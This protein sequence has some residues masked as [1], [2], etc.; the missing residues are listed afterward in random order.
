MDCFRIRARYKVNMSTS[1]IWM[2]GNQWVQVSTARQGDSWRER[3]TRPF[4]LSALNHWHYNWT[5]TIP[6]ASFAKNL[7]TFSTVLL[8]AHTWR[9]QK[10]KEA[11]RFVL[12]SQS[13]II[14]DYC[15]NLQLFF[16]TNQN[17]PPHSS[18]TTYHTFC[19]DMFTK[20]TIETVG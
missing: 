15:N 4:Q 2:K 12:N 5:E 3:A 1:S 19:S 11:W 7:S 14:S 20:F 8:K 6:F 17:P 10:D 9:K 16:W 18:C 13:V